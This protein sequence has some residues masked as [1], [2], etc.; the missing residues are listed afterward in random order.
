MPSQVIPAR[1]RPGAIRRG[2]ARIYQ[3]HAAHTRARREHDLAIERDP[4]FQLE[5][6]LHVAR[7]VDDGRG[8]CPYCGS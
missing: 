1:L 4:R 8:G 5:H 7:S 3:D 2:V 6:G